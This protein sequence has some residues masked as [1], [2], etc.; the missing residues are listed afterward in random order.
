MARLRAYTHFMDAQEI[1]KLRLLLG[2]SQKELADALGY[3]SEAAVSRFE[4]G[5]R[6]P[7]GP[8]LKALRRLALEAGVAK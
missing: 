5:A 1:K 6:Q 2:M 8:A 4:S 7:K 3:A